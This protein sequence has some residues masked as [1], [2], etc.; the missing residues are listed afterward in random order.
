MDVLDGRARFLPFETHAYFF[1]FERSLHAHK[2]SDKLGY[3][4]I[5][6]FVCLH[7]K[8]TKRQM[9]HCVCR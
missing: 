8:K 5:R 3:S 9:L 1:G 4:L 2:L 7:K 6:L